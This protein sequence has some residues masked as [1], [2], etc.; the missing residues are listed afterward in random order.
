MRIGIGIDTGGTC[1][2]AVAL[3]LDTQELL[4]KGKS[5]TTREDL[6]VGIGKA[7]DMLPEELVRRASIVS[8]ST[9]LA[10]NACIENKGCRAKLLIFGLTE[11][12]INR[13]NAS[14]TFSL[15]SDSVLCFDTH[16]SA[17]GLMIDEP[18]WEDFYV[19]YGDWLR[20]AD[21]LSAVCQLQRRSRGK[22][23]QRACGGADR[24]QMCLRK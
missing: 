10:T 16:G 13:V 20:D 12:N 18:D 5:L 1:T 15:K 4:A 6:S 8:L 21:A 3:D 2:D 14:E 22:T 7:L 23:L 24:V 19:Q 17:D 11:E 9:T